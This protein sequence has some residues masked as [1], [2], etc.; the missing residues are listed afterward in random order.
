[1]W[2]FLGLAFLLCSVGFTSAI[3]QTSDT[4][5]NNAAILGEGIDQTSNVA[6]VQA[7]PII[8][9]Q[10]TGHAERLDPL[11]DTLPGDVVLL[12]T[13]DADGQVTDAAVHRSSANTTFDE[14]AMREVQTYTFQP[15]TQDGVSL[16]VQILFRFK[17]DP[18][19]VASIKSELPEVDTRIGVLSGQILLKGRGTPLVGISVVLPG[20]GHETFTDKDGG[21]KFESLAPGKVTVLIE[22]TGFFTYR[23]QQVIGVN[24]Q[25]EVKY[26][27]EPETPGAGVLTVRA[28]RPKTEV[29]RRTVHIE[30][31]IKIP[32]VSGDVVKVVQN[33]PGVA[34]IPFG[35]GGLIIRGSNPGDAGAVVNGHF[36]PLIFHFGGLRSIL[37][38]ELIERLDFYPGNYSVR[39]G[40]FGGGIVD[41]SLKRPDQQWHMRAEA[42][43]FDAGFYLSGPLSDRTT[44]AVA[45]R[46]SY[47]DIL[48]PLALPEDANLDLTVAPRYYDYQFLV[49]HKR[50][51]VHAQFFVFGSDDALDF[52]LDEPINA[53]PALRGD[54]ENSTRFLRVYG[55][56]KLRLQDGLTNEASVSFGPNKVFAQLGTNLRFDN[57]AWVVTARDHID[58]EINDSHTLS[59]GLDF[60]TYQADLDIRAPFPPKEGEDRGQRLSSREVITAKRTTE[61]WNLAGWI[62]HQFRPFDSKLLLVSG[63][64]YDYD[65]RLS[66]GTWDPRLSARFTVMPE[67]WVLKSG[68]GWFSQRPSPDESDPS[69]GNPDI[70]AERSIHY[71]IG[72]EWRFSD[73]LDL[74]VVGF[75]KDLYDLIGAPKPSAEMSVAPTS[76]GRLL[77][78]DGQGRS[79]GLELLLRHEPSTHFFGWISYTLMRS[80]RLNLDTG[81]YRVFDFDQTHIFTILG[82][83]KFNARWELG[84]RFRWVTGLPQTPF[85][86][87]IYNSNEDVYE[88]IS[89]EKNSSRLPSFQQLDIRLD[90]NRRFDTWTFASYFEIQ[91]M[92][93]YENVEGYQYDY[94]FQ[95]KRPVTGLPII[96]SLGLKGHF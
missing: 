44:F 11:F 46:R 20:T 85:V 29:T 56:L 60:E 19:Q 72:T 32:G 66:E 8:P 91:N 23:D 45:G 53:D 54:F 69:F 18:P 17:V 83:Y 28:K 76:A 43:V 58:W 80:E 16:S 30:E 50:P 70:H 7:A 3:A 14:A 64:R 34:R 81:E 77:S 65:R 33:L 59:L 90:H 67:K 74:D 89:A 9:P 31:V 62:E 52:V 61:I 73:D 47:I 82:Q 75:Y 39:Y 71:S 10:Q 22:E 95:N 94:D 40:R 84:A 79:Y 2:R 48:L 21:F 6:E 13:I 86:G 68:V 36:V 87:S 1:M 37:P 93:N 15:A 63:V 41:L 55:K 4:D 25:T 78:N 96:P 35:G 92:Y 42:D 26:Y 27:I 24:E 5:K 57:Q 38:S 51:G 49:D 88:P 12:L